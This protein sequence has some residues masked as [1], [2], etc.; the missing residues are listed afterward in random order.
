MKY[1]TAIY[2]M[3]VE[4][5]DAWI[6]KPEAERKEAEATMK[7]QWD[8]WTEAHKDT[9]LKTIALGKTKK[10]TSAGVEDTRNGNMLSSYVQAESLEAA[11]DVFKD[12]PHLQIPSA[13][14]EVMETREM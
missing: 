10:V 6:A 1:F 4:G 5:L 9:V 3:P 14:I 13:I 2:S 7:T 8:A 12:H 11:A